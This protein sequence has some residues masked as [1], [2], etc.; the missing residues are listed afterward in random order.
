MVDAPDIWFPQ[1][2]SC[3]RLAE[4][5]VSDTRTKKGLADRSTCHKEIC[6]PCIQVKAFPALKVET[7]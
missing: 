4:R 3:Q 7:I 5:L 2:K 6:I 1:V